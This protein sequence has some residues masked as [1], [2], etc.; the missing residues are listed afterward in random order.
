MIPSISFQVDSRNG[1]DKRQVVVRCWGSFF[2]IRSLTSTFSHW[3]SLVDKSLDCCLDWCMFLLSQQQN[4]PEMFRLLF[5]ESDDASLAPSSC[6][7][8]QT[9]MS[10][11]P[12]F[13]PLLPP[14]LRRISHEKHDTCISC[15]EDESGW[16]ILLKDRMN[17]SL[18]W[19]LISLDDKL[20]R[21]LSVSSSGT[22]SCSWFIP[23]LDPL[24][25]RRWL[26]SMF[27]FL[28]SD[29]G[30]KGKRF[31]IHCLKDA[32]LLLCIELENSL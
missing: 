1:G 9:V 7:R 32:S 29:W 13:P 20:S 21:V 30:W 22:R 27:V 11:R 26:V 3:F 14:I 28:S 2:D 6:Q 31:W 5:F 24:I 10:F 15:P 23:I 17:E 12:L 19:K 25:L 8:K 4:Y 16:N 18:S